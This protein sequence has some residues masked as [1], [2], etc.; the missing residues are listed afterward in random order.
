[1]NMNA[2]QQAAAAKEFA[3]K[4]KGKGYEKGESQKFWFDLLKNVYGVENPTDFMECEVQVMLDHTSFIDV[5]L[6]QTK[7]MIEQKSIGKD[8]SKPIKQSDGTML[9]PMQQLKRYAAALGY[10]KYPRW[11]ITCNFAE[12]FIYDM[13]NPNSEPEIIKLADLPK[14]YN[15]LNFLVDTSHNNIKK[16]L[17]V[18]I[19]A[20]TLVGKMY[21]LILKQYGEN[22]TDKEL[23]SLNMLIVR[24]VFCMYAEDAGIFG[25][26]DMFVDYMNDFLPQHFRKALMDLFKILNIPEDERDP[27]E[28]KRLLAFPYVNGG[29]F[30]N[31][32]LIIPQFDQECI[33]LITKEACP[34]DWSEI[35]PTIFG[36]LFEST[37]ATK[38]RRVGGMHYTSVENI[39]KVIDP[40]FLNDL[41]AEYEKIIEMPQPKKRATY[42]RMFQDKLASLTFFDPACGSGNFLTETYISLR[43]LENQVIEKLQGAEI[44]LG[45]LANPVKVSIQQ[46]YGI[47]INDYAC[48]V[49]KTALW[50]A[51]LQMM[52]ET[53]ALVHMNLDF[54]P[55]KTYA[56]IVEGNALTVDWNK[57]VPKE[58]L[59]YIMGNPPFV[60]ARM[61]AQG[62]VQKEE[63]KHIFGDIKDVHDLDYVTC[64]YKLASNFIENTTIQ[65]CFVSTNSICQG[66]QVPILWNIILNEYHSKI[67][68][69][70][71]TFKW[72][73][74]SSNSAAVNCIIIGFASFDRKVKRIYKTNLPNGAVVSNISPY[75]VEGTDFFVTPSKVALCDVPKM[76]FG[77]QPRDGGNYIITEADREKIL[78]SEP[79]LEKWIHPYV[80]AEEFIKGKKR[81]CI[82]LKKAI[83]SDI[84]NS[85]ILYERVNNVREFRLASSAK[86]TKGYARVPHLFAQ[87]TQPDDTNYLIIPR[88]SSEKRRY[89][90]IG[91]MNSDNIS[92]DAVQIVP[93]ATLYHF[94]ILTSNVHMAWMRTVAGRLEMRYRYSKEIVYNTF[95]WPT[96]TEAQQKKI[97]QTAQGILDAR[98]KYPDSSLADLYDEVLMP[99]ELRKAHQANDRAV[100]EAYG[101]WGKLN[102]ES[103]C[104]AEL[105]K[106]YQQLIERQ[107]E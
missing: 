54:L 62:G 97:E 27:Y 56:N 98:A 59:N 53:Q 74:E 42:L 55:L 64:W 82:W 12:F 31:E 46:F 72:D 101:F 76:N 61:M 81:W 77:N 63:V 80:G 50:I 25:K 85:K 104:V 107:G 3:E 67:N 29:L 44:V 79:S 19:G 30:D 11:G 66:A 39:H 91:F 51:E 96:P 14:E 87:I 70:Y 33:D 15:R 26:K 47:E 60:G 94:G 9:T 84:K 68:F 90:P 13:A 10:F 86:T 18:S 105:M 17:E 36:A 78:L 20:G 22:P 40:L 49:A 75:L 7:V 38:A 95:P 58:R 65:V 2:A 73:S 71:E 103:A 93:N 28:E 32:N 5:Y 88:V 35:S 57:V 48:V 43:R 1:M 69:A 6:P 8:L 23:K 92:S 4:W 21:D 45:E 106:M 100:M 99:S 89:I 37:I 83:P 34:F 24:L 16:E 52:Q 102:S 41:K